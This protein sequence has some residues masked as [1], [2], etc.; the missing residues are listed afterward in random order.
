M[1]EIEWMFGLEMIYNRSSFTDMGS[2][3][4][5]FHL[6]ADLQRLSNYD[7]AIAKNGEG[8]TEWRE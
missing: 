2:S 5:Y 6:S 1:T 7:R 8:M 4:L 3:C